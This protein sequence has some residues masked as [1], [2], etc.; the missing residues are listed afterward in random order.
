MITFYLAEDMAAF[1]IVD[2]V[3]FKRLLHTLDGPYDL[4]SSKY[5][6]MAFCIYAVIGDRG[7]RRI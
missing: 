5:F 4:R 1:K 2:N 3:G 6:Y 7:L